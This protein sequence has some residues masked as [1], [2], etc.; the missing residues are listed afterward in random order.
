[1]VSLGSIFCQ[2]GT[3]DQMQAFHIWLGVLSEPEPFWWLECCCQAALLITRLHMQLLIVF[4]LLPMFG[5]WHTHCVMLIGLI[6]DCRRE[7]FVT[8]ALTKK[9]AVL[10]KNR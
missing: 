9:G 5:T 4:V 3:L 7:H 10:Y 8:H 2:H 6:A 1:M